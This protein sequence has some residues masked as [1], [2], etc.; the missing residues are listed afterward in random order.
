VVEDPVNRFAQNSK[1]GSQ[2]LCNQTV[3]SFDN[4]S[5]QFLLSPKGCGSN[6]FR[7]SVGLPIAYLLVNRHFTT[8]FH[9]GTGCHVYT[10]TSECKLV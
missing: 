4:F 3:E 2:L 7:T 8:C 5:E 10:S 1:A 6:A 9:A